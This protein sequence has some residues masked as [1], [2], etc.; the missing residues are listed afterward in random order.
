MARVGPHQTT[1]ALSHVLTGAGKPR[2][3]AQATRATPDGFYLP[4]RHWKYAVPERATASFPSR[5]AGRTSL[6]EEREGQRR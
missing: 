6:T 3:M 4:W 5:Q 2:E 1:S